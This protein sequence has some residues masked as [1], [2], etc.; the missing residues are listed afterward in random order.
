M[1][2]HYPEHFNTRDFQFDFLYTDW[3]HYWNSEANKHTT[4]R[5][6]GYKISHYRNSDGYYQLD[7]RYYHPFIYKEILIKKDIQIEDVKS[8]LD[9]VFDVL[10][11]KK[12]RLDI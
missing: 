3:Y 6:I 1:N 9:S 4:Y 10:I 11:G 12:M 5:G 7:L 2:K 8:L